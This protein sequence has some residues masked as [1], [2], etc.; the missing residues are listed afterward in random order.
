MPLLAIRDLRIEFPSGAG[1]AAAVVDGVSLDIAAGEA[2]AL[3]GESGCGKS[4]T[5]LSIGRLV[6]SP[7]ARYT[8]GSILLDGREV[9]KLDEPELRRLRGAVVSYVFQEP[10]AA[11]NPVMRIGRQIREMLELHRPQDNTETEA[12]RLLRSVGI[13]SPE[14]R[15]R[16]WPHQLSGGMQQR[17]M[18]AMAVAAHPKLLVADEPTTALDA[19]VQAQILELLNGLRRELGMSLLLITHNLRIV[20]RV[21][22]RV[23]VMYAGQMVEEGPAEA[24]LTH[25]L[26][27]YTK[28]LLGSIPQLRSGS[29]R[30]RAIP[31]QVPRAG[32][33]PPGCRFHPRCP[34]ARPECAQQAPALVELVPGRR[35]RCPYAEPPSMQE[36]PA[37][38]AA[39]ARGKDRP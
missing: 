24:V 7:P 22:G 27:P 34:I 28:G 26:H 13:A 21:A 17:A 2:V 10:G 14:T 38:P 12:A 36:P 11:L 23:C 9:L 30:L 16:Q 20:A 6:A 31:G 8:A 32:R 37:F 5:A 33:M 39:A 25:P 4:M 29:A 35:V 18:I 15:A 3:V 1:A 19:T